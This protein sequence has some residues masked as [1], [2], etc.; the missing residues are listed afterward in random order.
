MFNQITSIKKSEYVVDDIVDIPKSLRWWIS[1]Q[2]FY[3]S[4]KYN[5]SKSV[6]YMKYGKLMI[7]AREAKLISV[8]FEFTYNYDYSVHQSK[9]MKKFEQAKAFYNKNGHCLITPSSTEVPEGLVCWV[10]K[11]HKELKCNRGVSEIQI[12]Q[13]KLLDSIGFK[14]KIYNV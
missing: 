3:F 10:R 12:K 6:S 4:I 14:W 5:S 2:R 8:G 11:E 13:K 9:W 1:Q 7:C